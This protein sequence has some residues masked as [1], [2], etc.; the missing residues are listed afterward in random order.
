M[1]VEDVERWELVKQL[2]LAASSL[3]IPS[4]LEYL[5]AACGSDELLRKEVSSLLSFLNSPKGFLDEPA[6][7]SVAGQLARVVS[8]PDLKEGVSIGHYQI[9]RTIGS[10]G[11][12]KVYL[13]RDVAL[14]REAAIKFIN[15]ELTTSEEALE[16]FL[17]EARLASSLNHPNIL[18]VYEIAEHNGMRFLATEYIV[19]I[20]LREYMQK[21]R[22]VSLVNVLNI[23]I[24]IAKGLEAGHRAGIIHRDIKPENVM[25]RKDGYLKI[26]DFGLAKFRRDPEESLTASV[27]WHGQGKTSGYGSVKGTAAYMSPEQTIGNQVDERADLWS[28]GVILY[29]LCSGHLPF[30]GETLDDL[31]ESIRSKEPAALTGVPL[32]L[33]G[34]IRRSLTKDPGLRYLAAGELLED[35]RDLKRK[36]G[37]RGGNDTVFL[38]YSDPDV[39]GEK[40]ADRIP[41]RLTGGSNRAPGFAAFVMR[42]R[43]RLGVA[44]VSAVLLFAALFQVL[45]SAIGVKPDTGEIDQI[46]VLQFYNET[47]S[48]ELDYLASDLTEGLISSL[49][50]IK[51][52]RVRASGSTPRYGSGKKQLDSIGRALGVD[53][54]IMGRLSTAKTGLAL[55]LELV[56]ARSESVLWKRRYERSAQEL[57]S[58]QNEIAR[59]IS[60]EVV[61]RGRSHADQEFPV[62]F[63]TTTEAYRAYLKGKYLIGLRTT[64]SYEKAIA[65]FESSIAEDPDFA[66]SYAEIADTYVILGQGGASPGEAFPMAEA[67][68]RKALAIDPKLAEAYA[69]MGNIAFLYYFDLQD[70]EEQFRRSIR[71]N[72]NYPYSYSYY[73]HFLTFQGRFDEALANLKMAESLDPVSYKIGT[74]IAIHHYAAR[75]YG[76]AIDQC[77]RIL[78]IYPEDTRVLLLLSRIYE[79]TKDY[80]A[81]AEAATRG[82]RPAE[83]VASRE[84]ERAYRRGGIRALWSTQLRILKHTTN[85]NDNGFEKATR[86]VLLGNNEAALT[87]LEVAAGKLK[88]QRDTRLVALTV[89]P[90][91]DPLRGHPRFEL[92]LAKLKGGN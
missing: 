28:L 37:S 33:Q 73:G 17:M 49:S 83:P 60:F 66:M 43:L 21:R 85:S 25:V 14:D 77:K 39:V 30:E 80:E 8:A 16:R 48:P 78:E 56:D 91:F 65:Y 32:E 71:L 64:D 18:T 58:L 53:A 26:L 5:R 2:F 51:D 81:A 82:M 23:G 55:D 74:Q 40:R 41:K 27:H 90:V 75:Q 67:A 92:V 59:S 84:L 11:M 38:P 76:L 88:E 9:I 44:V 72:P 20:T 36:L 68:A 86:Q 47:G 45:D 31:L 10:G 12:G 54:F 22:S 52:L 63:R 7:A 29:E 13:A 87:E 19:G 24:Q 1:T 15:Q 57:G 70:A 42:S 6:V 79:V 34:A 4:R 69:A 3:E 89:E 62:Q 46:A 50:G 35:L 61:A